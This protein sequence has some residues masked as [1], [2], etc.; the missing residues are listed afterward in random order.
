MAPL[1]TVKLPASVPPAMVH[2]CD[3]N[4]LLGFDVRRHV[5]PSQ[6]APEAETPVP[7][8]PEFGPKAK[9]TAGGTV[10]VAVPKSP[11]LPVTVTVYV[12]L[13]TPATTK[14]PDIAPPAT[15]HTGLE[16]NPGGD[17]VIAHPVSPPAKPEPVTKTLVPVRPTVGN[18]ASFAV[19]VNGA[20]PKSPVMPF[21]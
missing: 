12:P 6:L 7:E 8:G 9:V 16:I 4:R 17:E 5:V 11:V 13:A 21:T 10:N 2:D 3:A 1:A 20:V 19:T 15:V 18:N 14:V